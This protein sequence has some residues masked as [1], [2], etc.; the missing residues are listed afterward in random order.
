MCFDCYLKE[1]FTH[2]L[3]FFPFVVHWPLIN[4][5]L[6][7]PLDAP[8]LHNIYSVIPTFSFM[9]IELTSWLSIWKTEWWLWK[10]LLAAE[11]NSS[12]GNW[13]SNHLTEWRWID[14]NILS[15]NGH[16][17]YFYWWNEMKWMEWSGMKME[18]SKMKMRWSG[19]SQNLWNERENFFF[20]E[21]Y[22]V[23]GVPDFHSIFSV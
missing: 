19:M 16:E 2:T 6:L 9:I 18:W 17:R 13:H 22:R 20:F 3:E 14:D 7:M 15:E 21:K 23:S 8:W 4:C 10:L 11:T 5:S 1:I 12:Y